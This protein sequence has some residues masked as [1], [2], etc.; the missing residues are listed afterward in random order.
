MRTVANK[1][2]TQSGKLTSWLPT[3]SMASTQEE[4]ESYLAF[5]QLNIFAVQLLFQMTPKSNYT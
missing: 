3:F 1:Y 5:F 2:A 4:E